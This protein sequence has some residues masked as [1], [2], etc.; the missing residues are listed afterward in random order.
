[1]TTKAS[2]LV[3]QAKKWASHYGAFTGGAE[4]A[5]LSAPLRV[6]GAWENNDANVFADVFTENGSML[7][8]NEQ[9][10]SREAIRSYMAEAF[11]GKYKGSSIEDDP[12]DIFFLAPDVAL[13]IS[14]GG[15]LM[16]GETSL[17]PGRVYRTT[18]VVVKQQFQNEWKLLSYQTSP[19]KG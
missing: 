13:V 19:T 15:V 16:S 14:L 5:V 11:A 17:P 4:G 2:L 3:D 6:R 8:G 1:M 7:I 18:W 10:T 9:L 12:V